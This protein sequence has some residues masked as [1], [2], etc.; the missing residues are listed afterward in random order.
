M[1]TP[2]AEL[3]SIVVPVFNRAHVIDATLDSIVAQTYPY[4][5]VTVVDD[6]SSDDTSEAVSK[7]SRCDR[8]IQ[9]VRFGRNRGAQAARNAGI[10]AAR[11]DWIAFVDSDDRWL[12]ESLETR[13]QIAQEKGL[14]VVH[15]ECDVLTADGSPSRRFGVP[16]MCGRIYENVLE[17]PG[18]MFQGLLVKTDAFTQIGYLDESIVSYQEWDTSIRLAKYFEFGFVEEPTF[19]YDCRLQVTI[20]KDKLRTARGYEQVVRKHR[21]PILRRAGRN[22]LAK[23][24]RTAATLYTD[25]DATPDAKR[26]AKFAGLLETQPIRSV[27]CRTRRA[28]G[29]AKRWLL[30]KNG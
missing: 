11:G 13:L 8:R 18:P 12:P 7:R 29:H 9:L 28:A 2:S 19:V 15:S 24:Y 1:S 10:R 26:C 21:W 6:G 25:A 3:V 22:A 30:A 27:L 14:Q 17:G 4:W 20:S 16:H 5:E 23:H